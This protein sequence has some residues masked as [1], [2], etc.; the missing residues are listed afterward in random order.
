[1]DEKT[2]KYYTLF[3]QESLSQILYRKQVHELLINALT[4]EEIDRLIELNLSFIR[5]YSPSSKIDLT[6]VNVDGSM[7]LINIEGNLI[8]NLVPD[9]I[10]AI[11]LHEIGHAFNPGISGIEG[12]YLADNFAKEKGYG[13]WVISSL[14]KGLKRK[15]LG[16]DEEEFELRKQNILSK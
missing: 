2:R 10:A 14:E 12:E 9:E 11:L 13:K 3:K 6:G 15:W 4:E 7:T 16:F 8:N 5:N 1:M